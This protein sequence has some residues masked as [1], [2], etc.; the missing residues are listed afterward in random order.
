MYSYKKQKQKWEMTDIYFQ[1]R[2]QTPKKTFKISHQIIKKKFKNKNIELLDVGS[3]ECA[4][5]FYLSQKNKKTSVTNLEYDNKLV[6]LSKKNFPN[7]KIIR[8]DINSCKKIKTNSFNVITCLG[9]MSIF[10][11]FRPSLNEMIRMCKKSGLIIINNMWNSF[12]IDLN[13][14]IRRSSSVKKDNYMNWESGWNMISVATMSKYLDEHKKVKKFTFRN[15]HMDIDLKK[16]NSNLMRAWTIK[17]SKNQRV[18]FNG[19]GREIDKKFLIIE[20]K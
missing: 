8:G 11:D 12:P 10:D 3:A 15:W 2:Y 18:H 13:I 6:Q 20:K 17:N 7:F 1:N 4:F 9:V 16:K 19:I 5:S 14:K